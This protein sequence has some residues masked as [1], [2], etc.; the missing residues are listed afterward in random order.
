LFQKR[1]QTRNSQLQAYIIV[2][3]LLEN[4]AKNIFSRLIVHI[5]MNDILAPEQ[6]GFRTHLSTEKAA[7]SL[8]DSILTAM[9]S[10]QVVGGVFCDL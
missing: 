1:K 9:N 8:L 6:Y 3:F 10:K 2:D 4:Y 7:F 5:E